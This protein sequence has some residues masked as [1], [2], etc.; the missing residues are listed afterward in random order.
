VLAVDDFAT[1]LLEHLDGG[2]GV[3]ELTDH[4]VRDLSEGRLALDGVS[5]SSVREPRVR[6]LLRRNIERLLDTFRRAGVVT[7]GG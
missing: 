4:L 5:P 7:D 1:R 6:D 2:R 3:D